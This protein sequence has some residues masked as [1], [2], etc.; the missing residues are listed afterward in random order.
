MATARIA[1]NALTAEGKQV[2]EF[3]DAAMVALEK[4]RRLKAQFMAMNSDS[5]A[6]EAEVG[7]MAVGAGNDMWF[8]LNAAIVAID[9]DALNVG[10]A[11]L[12]QGG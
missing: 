8:L 10:L 2:A 11:R 4:G 6:I 3:V 1:Y 5:A 12:D 7:G 9:V